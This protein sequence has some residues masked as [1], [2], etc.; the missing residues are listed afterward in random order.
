MSNGNLINRLVPS[1]FW[2]ACGNCE[3]NE[4]CK[5]SP[6]HPAYPHTWHWGR[7]AITLPEGDLIIRSWVGTA[8]IGAPHTGCTEYRVTDTTCLPLEDRHRQLIVLES[9]LKSL[10]KELSDAEARNTYNTRL[11]NMYHQLEELYSK[12]EALINPAQESTA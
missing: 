12:R 1:G 6:A 8:E 4:Q 9:R 10:D 7:E 3:H 11:A 5:V 2:P